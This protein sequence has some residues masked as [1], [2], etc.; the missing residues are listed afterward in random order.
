MPAPLGPGWKVEFKVQCE[1]L[2][3]GFR[4]QEGP[5]QPQSRSCF[6]LHTLLHMRQES[7]DICRPAC[8]DATSYAE[9]TG[10]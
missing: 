6:L 5:H 10:E 8:S 2:S 7:F 3:L 9:R 1:D 4:V